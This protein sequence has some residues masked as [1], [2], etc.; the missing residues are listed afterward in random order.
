MIALRTVS[1]VSMALLA[2]SCASTSQKRDSLCD[3][4]AAFANAR[5]G[6]GTRSV[7]LMTDWGETSKGCQHGGDP[8]GKKLCSYLLKNSST[9]FAA[10]NYRRALT[11]LGN[12][13]PGSPISTDALPASVRSQTVL[14]TRVRHEVLIEFTPESTMALPAMSI[15]VTE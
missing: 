5:A 4:I 7:R 1:V 2:G 3:E 10:V 9:E 15:S 12:A 11:C 13:V 6:H 14:G 8:P